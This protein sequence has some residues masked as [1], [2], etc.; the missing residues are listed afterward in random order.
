[1]PR[2]AAIGSNVRSP[3]RSGR[4]RAVAQQAA[5]D[6]GGR[7]PV[8]R[9]A[10]D[11]K[12]REAMLAAQSTAERVARETLDSARAAMEDARTAGAGCRHAPNCRRAPASRRGRGAARRRGAARAVAEE[13]A[14]SSLAAAREHEATLRGEWEQHA[15]AAAERAAQTIVQQ[16]VH[17]AETARQS[18]GTVDDDK[19]REAML[20]V[21]STAERV[22]RE[23]LDSS[24]AEME[25]ASRR[26]LESARADLQ[27]SVRLAAE[28][29][30]RPVAEAR[31]A[32]RRSSKWRAKR[33]AAALEGE[34]ASRH[35]VEQRA[36]EV[37]E[38]VG[39]E[40]VQLAFDAATPRRE[41]ASGEHGE[42]IPSLEAPGAMPFG[43]PGEAAHAA[44]AAPGP[45]ATE[46]PAGPSTMTPPE[47]PPSPAASSLQRAL[48]PWLAALTLAV[49]VLLVRSFL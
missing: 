9:G 10:T 2:F 18:T 40:L 1:M 34:A 15:I 20:A 17:E 12:L 27:E 6:A 13:M 19:L 11:E 39:R 32:R 3:P 49:L 43:Q 31:G 38:R 8:R 25:D 48:L 14:R 35:R 7:A 21:Q 36:I 24:K 47:A 30:A 29:A 23:T 22:A 26:V 44:T 4:R 33:F 5:D 42:A 28:A 41:V 46:T 45:Q 37:A 16:A